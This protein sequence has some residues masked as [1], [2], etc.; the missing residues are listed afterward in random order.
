MLDDTSPVGMIPGLGLVLRA[1][2]YSCGVPNGYCIHILNSIKY[3][4]M[5]KEVVLMIY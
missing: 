5:G 3:D 4:L 2:I 1:N